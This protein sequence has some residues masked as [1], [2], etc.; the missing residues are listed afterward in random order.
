VLICFVKNYAQTAA[1]VQKNIEQANKQFVKWFNNAQADSIVAQ[2]H[3]SACI[4]GR[5][6][7]KEFLQNYYN[8]ETGKY[9]FQELTTLTVTVNGKNATETG[10]WKILLA[11]GVELSGKYSTEWQQVNNRWVIFKETVLE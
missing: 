5:G 8:A 3:T 1:S 9:T 6:C 2:Y 10:R 4:T 11:S 7:G